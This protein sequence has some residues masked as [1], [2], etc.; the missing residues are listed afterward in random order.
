MLKKTLAALVAAGAVLVAATPATS[1]EEA[2][3]C[4]G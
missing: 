3:T 4:G 1:Q 2:P